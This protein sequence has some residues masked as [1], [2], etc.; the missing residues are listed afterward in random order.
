MYEFHIANVR[1]VGVCIF[2]LVELENIKIDG[3]GFYKGEKQ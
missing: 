3:A 1:N 2:C